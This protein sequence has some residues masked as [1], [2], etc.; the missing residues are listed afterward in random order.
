[1]RSFGGVVGKF[2]AGSS[3][4]FGLVRSS[5]GLMVVLLALDE[6]GVAEAVNLAVLGTELELADSELEEEREDG[7]TS[8]SSCWASERCKQRLRSRDGWK[9]TRHFYRI[10]SVTS[11]TCVSDNVQIR[12][13]KMRI[14]VPRANTNGS[15]RWRRTGEKKGDTA[16]SRR[17]M[18][19]LQVGPTR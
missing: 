9:E 15:R 11:T 17:L 18:E 12:E 16:T 7:R 10:R 6:C 1:M 8:D 2:S 19:R 14:E 13:E 5:R 4:R 3:S